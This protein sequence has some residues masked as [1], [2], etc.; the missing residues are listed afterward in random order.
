MSSMP[1]PNG[2]ITAVKVSA[3]RTTARP[4][5]SPPNFPLLP[6]ELINGDLLTAPEYVNEELVLLIYAH[7]FTPEC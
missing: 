4:L 5:I 3:A 6:L 2:T 7:N 1:H